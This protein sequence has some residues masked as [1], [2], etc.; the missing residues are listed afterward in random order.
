LGQSLMFNFT[1]GSSFDM[2]SVDLAGYSSVVPDATIQ[3]VGYRADGSTVM[4]NVDRHG[5]VFDT[6][7][8]G[9]GFSDLT[10]VEIPNSLWSLDNLTV[11]IPEPGTGTLGLIA[12]TCG[13]VGLRPHR[14]AESVTVV[15]AVALARRVE[16][17]RRP[18][19]FFAG[20]EGVGAGGG[21]AVGRGGI[22]AGAAPDSGDG[23]DLFTTRKPR[24][25]RPTSHIRMLR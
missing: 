16:A 13:V 6:M 24:A 18:F 3:F 5:I 21:V 11:S 1:N 17:A 25:A 23:P 12:I 9:P 7:Y 8:F 20:F 4:T 10:R 22:D 15:R 2:L 19:Y 14:R